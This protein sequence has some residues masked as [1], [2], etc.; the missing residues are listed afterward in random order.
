MSTLDGRPLLLLDVDGV[1]SPTGAGVPP[2]YERRSTAR[3][4]VVV[5]PQHGAWLRRL[6]VVYELTW[7]TTW[8]HAAN[9][10]YA[11]LFDLPQ[12][13]VIALGELP[14]S[15]TRKLAPVAAYAGARDLA[16]I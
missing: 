11:D 12:L 13:P 9:R 14:R 7:A 15:G 8:E 2:G 16:W 1:L 10:V 3:Y 5:R 6:A 4:D